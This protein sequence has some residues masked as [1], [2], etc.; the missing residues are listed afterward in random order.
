[1]K[2]FD[3][4]VEGRIRKA[5]SRAKLELFIACVSPSIPSPP[6]TRSQARFHELV[7]GVRNSMS[8]EPVCLIT[9][10]TEVPSTRISM[11]G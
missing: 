9:A 5:K 11:W 4:H 1:M 2:C 6:Q 7:V 10:S 3:G 8:K